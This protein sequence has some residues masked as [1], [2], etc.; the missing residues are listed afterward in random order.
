MFSLKVRYI[1]SVYTP[2][3]SSPL[4]LQLMGITEG[5]MSSQP[6]GEGDERH[7]VCVL[8]FSK[9]QS[10]SLMLRFCFHYLLHSESMEY[11]SPS[12]YFP[13]PPPPLFSPLLLW[14]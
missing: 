4:I 13:D 11:V 5:I 6:N 9:E 12:T 1:T 10:S 8:L 3:P 7:D 2:L 14:L